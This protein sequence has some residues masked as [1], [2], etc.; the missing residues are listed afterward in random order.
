M[1]ALI[2]VFLCLILI[3]ANR[4][5][6]SVQLRPAVYL[7]LLMINGGLI[8]VFGF[9]PIIRATQA[10]ATIIMTNAEV[11]LGVSVVFAVLATALLFEGVR[12]RLARFFPG[13]HTMADSAVAL[14]TGG[15]NPASMTHMIALV[16]CVYLLAET[17]LE[18]VIAGGLGGL[19]QQTK[20]AISGGSAALSPTSV[21]A[22][23]AIWLVIAVLG[24]GLLSR[25]SWPDVQR[26][27]GLRW[28]TIP[29]MVIS[30]SMSGVLIIFAFVVGIIWQI[31][32]PPSTFDQ[33][34][35]LSQLI[36]GG[37]NTLGFAFLIAFSAAVGEEIAFRGALQPIF[38]L[39]PTA[40]FFALTHVQ[41]TLT[42][43]T[44]LIIGVALG[45]GW[46]RQRY[47]TTA[48]IIAHFAY[49]FT[50]LALPLYLRYLQQV[51]GK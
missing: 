41:Y 48:S 17:I 15:F 6:K 50:L 3:A 35:Q 33:Q 47:N 42:P 16:Y 18:F 5:E 46:L 23:L 38:G 51:V 25:R 14:P 40:I 11:G 20:D 32:T 31:V 45:L 39:W 26:R 10:N 36:A 24:T 12:R 8:V 43:A 30:V 13:Q 44:L 29:E 49:D 1:L 21:V 19:T 34:T 37:V 2:V 7:I 27:L 9:T 28:P 4:A 22:Q